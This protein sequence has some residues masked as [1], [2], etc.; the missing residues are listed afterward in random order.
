MYLGIVRVNDRYRF[1]RAVASGYEEATFEL[2]KHG[3]VVLIT[4]LREVLSELIAEE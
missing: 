2:G 3:E 4:P 1:V